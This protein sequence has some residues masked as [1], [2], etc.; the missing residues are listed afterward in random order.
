MPCISNCV[1]CDGESVCKMCDNG[2]GLTDSRT[3]QKCSSPCL[4]CSRDTANTCLSCNDQTILQSGMCLSTSCSY[5][6]YFN[7][8]TLSCQQCHQACDACT[9]SGAN[10]CKNCATNYFY[11]Q[12]E[13]GSIT[14]SLCG[15]PVE[16]VL[17]ETTGLS[18]LQTYF[19]Y[20]EKS[21]K[22]TD[23]CGDGKRFTDSVAKQL[24]SYI[25]CDDG[26]TKNGD[27]C[28]FEC[29]V[30]EYWKC[31]G[32][33]PTTPDVC[34][35]S[36]YP[37]AKIKEVADDASFIYVSFDES[38]SM[39][40]NFSSAVEFTIPALNT[41]DYKFSFEKD[42]SV[43]FKIVLSIYQSLVNGVANIEFTDRDQFKNSLNYSL[44]T[45]NLQ[46]SLPK[47]EEV[48][49]EVQEQALAAAGT[50]ATTSSATVIVTAAMIASAPAAV[51]LLVVIEK[52]L[53][54]MFLNI[55]LPKVTSNFMQ[56]FFGILPM[57][58]IPQPFSYLTDM[59][60]VDDDLENL[61]FP[62]VFDEVNFDPLFLEN[63]GAPFIIT[64]FC[65]GV[66]ILCQ[67]VISKAKPASLTY[68]VCTKLIA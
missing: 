17:N 19:A 65:F 47:I 3:C 12:L 24:G 52:V 59:L 49:S 21:G 62:S 1:S 13:Q 2:Y 31:E 44:S 26:N 57:K 58:I 68:T 8:T 55:N 34:V 6:Q 27:G 66:L 4:D 37:V 43:R 28:S 36:K 23:L 42:T 40:S 29:K 67:A 56:S 64:F 60:N 48:L 51:Q 25:Q 16:P 10:N 22:C 32:G 45:E 11:S 46:A 33:S 30:E 20:D 9:G 18:S 61:D 38:V 54:L 15:N 35:Y 7:R 63:L 50:S 39:P 41:Q 53:Y 14:C 5:S